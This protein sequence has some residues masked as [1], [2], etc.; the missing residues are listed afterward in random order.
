ML[1]QLFG[2]SLALVLYQVC[3]SGCYYGHIKTDILLRSTIATS[4]PLITNACDM[5]SPKPRAP[6]VITATRPSNEKDANVLLLCTPPRPC[7]GALLGSLDSSGYSTRTVFEVRAMVPSC[8]LLCT[9]LLFSLYSPGVVVIVRAVTAYLD[10]PR[11]LRVRQ[12]VLNGEDRIN[13]RA[14]DIVKQV[15]YAGFERQSNNE[16]IR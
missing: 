2:L 6:P 15:C 1:H 11:M 9:E 7:T 16:N 12:Q 4:A 3:V 8:S 5:T 10:V 13:A 14:V